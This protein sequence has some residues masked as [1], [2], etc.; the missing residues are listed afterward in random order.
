MNIHRL[1]KEK[2]RWNTFES[3]VLMVN[4]FISDV[5]NSETRTASGVGVNDWDILYSVCIF[6]CLK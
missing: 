2:Y 3:S 4:V 1:S 6:K 5:G